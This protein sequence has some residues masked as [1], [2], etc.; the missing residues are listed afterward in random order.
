MHTYTIGLT[1]RLL[2][3]LLDIEA[4][5]HGRG[6][7]ATANP[8]TL[9]PPNRRADRVPL[10][11]GRYDA[12]PWPFMGKGHAKAPRDGKARARQMEDLHCALIDVTSALVAVDRHGN[13]RISDDDYWLLC[14]YY[15]FQNYTL[16][17]LC[18]QRGTLSK[19]SMQRRCQRA[20]GRLVQE[21]ERPK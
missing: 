4:T 19:G 16:D 5:L 6:Q 20:I 8:T 3:N 10:G 9:T 14:E 1:E 7:H 17:E 2:R 21:L 13:Y 11:Q 15:I 18:A 12:R